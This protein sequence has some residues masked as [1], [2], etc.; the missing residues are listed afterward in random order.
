MQR[1]EVLKLAGATAA[2]GA[3]TPGGGAAQGAAESPQRLPPGLDA[4]QFNA[5]LAE[6]RQAVGDAWVFNAPKDLEAYKDPF[7]PLAGT[8]K[9]PL[10]AAVVAPKAV[11]EVQAAV[12]AANKFRI[13]L[14]VVSTGKN[15]GYGGTEAIVGGSVI[16]D[17]K[18]MDR[19]LEVNEELA[20]AIVEPGVSQYQLWLHCQK[21]GLKVWVDGP[22][23]AWS[24][25]VANTLERGVGYGPK[26]ERIAEACGLEVVLPDGELLRTG[27]GALEGSPTFATYKYGLG[28]WVDGLFSQSNLG[29]VT[30]MGIHLNPQPEC[31]R[32]IAIDVPNYKQVVDLIDVLRPLR[33]NG[34]VRS[35]ASIVLKRPPGVS[36]ADMVPGGPGAGGGARPPLPMIYRMLESRLG[37]R[38]RIGVGGHKRQVAADWAEIHE[39]FKARIPDCSIGSDYYEAPYDYDQMDTLGKLHAAIPSMQ[40]ADG[41]W[42]HSAAF[43]S[44]VLPHSGAAFWRQLE[45]MREVYGRFDLP[46][47]G[48]ALHFHAARSMMCLLGV[49][50][51]AGNKAQNAQVV[52]VGKAIIKAA[53][54]NG[55]AEYRAATTFMQAASEVLS[56]NNHALRRFNESIKDA[57]DPN[58]ILAPGKNGVWPARMRGP[59]M[60]T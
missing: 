49:P 6:F 33:L 31:L 8:A 52:Q 19:I 46:Y 59:G 56:F 26:G 42:P 53:A 23:P 5:A 39:T 15:F 41:I 10:C 44:T 17:L 32:S 12:Q 29:V 34:T 37:W 20:Y 9:Q 25:V 48:S 38:L 16:L 30:K 4:A 40:E 14:W 27:M 21:N 35:A 51:M 2:V 24:S 11:S 45:L 7:S 47:I 50:I 43:I 58:G 18:R 36:R 13:P 54:D 22:S 28:P 60:R 3:L 1:R 55:W 57:I